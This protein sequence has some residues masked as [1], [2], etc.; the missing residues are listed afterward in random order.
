[1]ST[2]V[3]RPMTGWGERKSVTLTNGVAEATLLPGGGHVAGWRLVHGR[4]RSDANLLWEAP[5][6][7]ADPDS[8]ECGPLAESYDDI[9]A[10]RF[11]A[12]Y[13]GHALCLD[14]FGPP[15]APEVAAGVALHGEASTTMWTFA[16]RQENNASGVVEL[17]VAG[18]RVERQ[19]SLLAEESVLRVDE[20]VTNL[21]DT[22]RNLHW[23]QHATFGA[24]FAVSG[25]ARTTA[26]VHRAT[27][28]PLDYEG[29]DLLVRDREFIWPNVP[30][31]D[32]TPADLRELFIRRGTGLV[33]AARQA[34][35][36]EHGFVAVCNG[37]AARAVGYVFRTDVF[38]WLTIWE[39]N[40]ARPDAPWMGT[41]EVRG[42]EFGTTPLPL[43]NE[44]VD[45]RGPLFETPTSRNIAARQTL[46]APWLLFAAEIPRGWREVEDIRIERDALVLLHGSEQ[47]RLHARGIEQFLRGGL[48]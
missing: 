36:R 6:K 35:G 16:A 47:V 11:L 13:T 27:T 22:E 30:A 2:H 29:H 4:G 17:P 43:G 31:V 21:R 44:A 28:W 18:L 10:G 26:S 34:E 8:P 33:A 19:F 20:R 15:S 7:T 25:S 48:A 23:V 24:P 9:A 1:M 46:R 45:A 32:G 40:C 5:W 41:S 14:G 3:A 37:A 12:S 39:E 38:P 42:M